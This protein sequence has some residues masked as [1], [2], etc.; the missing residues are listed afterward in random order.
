MGGAVSYHNGVAAENAV[1][2]HLEKCGHTVAERRWKTRHGEIDLIARKD[3]VVVFVEVKKS[4]SFARA[5]ASLGQPQI[6][7][8]FASASEFLE[9]E[10]NGQ[11]TESRFDVA[12]VNQQGEIE[13]LENALTA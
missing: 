6:A 10:P 8:L 3:G 2:L 11:N 7:R 4:S 12:L 5:A 1:A 13:V 9:K